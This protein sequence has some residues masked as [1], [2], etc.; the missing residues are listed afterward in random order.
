M[1][2]LGAALNNYTAAVLSAIVPLGI[3]AAVALFVILAV[4]GVARR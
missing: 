4:Y 3:V 2:G 1:T